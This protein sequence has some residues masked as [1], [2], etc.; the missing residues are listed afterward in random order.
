M[1]I[2]VS[3]VRDLS[4]YDLPV[5]EGVISDVIFEGPEELLFGGAR[6]TDTVALASAC[7]TLEGKRP[8]K[9]TVIVPR[10]LKDQPL[11]AQEWARKCADEIIEIKSPQLDTEAYRRRNQALVNKA[12]RLVAFWDGQSSG[13]GMTIDLARKAGIPVEIIK[14]LGLQ[15]K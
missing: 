15:V 5:I 13:T 4:P 9:L 10:C 14:V 8:P 2:A 3:G 7:T 12:D 11:E 6:G 1:N